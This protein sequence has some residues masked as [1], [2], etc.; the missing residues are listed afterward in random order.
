MSTQQSPEEGTGTATQPEQAP[1][2]KPSG[3]RFV[4]GALGALVLAGVI[5]AV[6]AIAGVFS[7]SSKKTAEGTGKH[8][9]AT[10]ASAIGHGAAQAAHVNAN[11]ASSGTTSCGGDLFVGPSTSCD[12]AYNVEQAYVSSTGGNTYVYVYSPT[13]SQNYSM[14]CTGDLPHVCTG[15][16]NA[17]VYFTSGPGGTIPGDTTNCGSNVYAGTNTSCDFAYNVQQAYSSSGAWG[18]QT[19]FA[20]SPTT[21]QTYEMYCTAGSPH[22]CT[23]GD[24]ASVYFP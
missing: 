19:V 8:A 15:A 13:T 6:L 21:G 24:N 2:P 18:S 11:D 3:N 14:Y 22:L 12:F 17:S 9:A 4:L 20:Y 7:S 16:N 23:G 1:Q 5:V 10:G